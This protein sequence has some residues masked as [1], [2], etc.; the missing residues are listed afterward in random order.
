GINNRGQLVGNYERP[1]IGGGG[2]ETRA[3]LYSDGKLTDLGTLYGKITPDV[4]FTGAE[5]INEQGQIVGRATDSNQNMHGFLYSNGVMRDLGTIGARA[6][7]AYS[8]NNFGDI[9]G[10]IVT[11]PNDRHAFIYHDGLMS[12]LNE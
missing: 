1:T 3:F 8:I 6:S 7:E 10:E 4:P 11:N 2:A 9:V 12:N 5:A